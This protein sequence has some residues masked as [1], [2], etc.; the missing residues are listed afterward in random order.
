[1]G[2]LG[3]LNRKKYNELCPVCNKPVH[4]FYTFVGD[5]KVHIDCID[6]FDE[7]NGGL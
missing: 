3:G 1:M 7:K 6:K 2:S 5:L 4:N